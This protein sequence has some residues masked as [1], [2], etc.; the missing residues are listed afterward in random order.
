MTKRKPRR[1]DLTG[2]RFGRL[3]VLE[4][5]GRKTNGRVPIWQCKCDCGQIKDVESAS[6]VRGNTSSCGCFNKDRVAETHRKHGQYT[7]PMYA[8]WTQMKARCMN[9]RHAGFKYYGG[10]GISVCQRWIDSFSAFLADMGERPDG[11]EIDRIN[12]DGNYEPGNCRW[13]TRAQQM[14]NTRR[15]KPRMAA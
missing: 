4:F 13:A 7:N 10:R 15:N 2:R 5:T 1:V 9:P 8:V 6:L 12:N 11:L 14:M 3:V